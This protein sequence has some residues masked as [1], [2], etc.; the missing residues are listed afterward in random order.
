MQIG[1]RM[2]GGAP[3]KSQDD[4]LT[5]TTNRLT[6]RVND[7]SEA[8]VCKHV[9]DLSDSGMREVSKTKGKGTVR[10]PPTPPSPV[11]RVTS[12]RCTGYEY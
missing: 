12:H 7:L 2:A 3:G 4:T 1:K 6:V 8:G 11:V 5:V 9:D 10:T